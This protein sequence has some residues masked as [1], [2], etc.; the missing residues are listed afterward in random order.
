MAIVLLAQA[1]RA[2]GLDALRGLNQWKTV[3]CTL[4]MVILVQL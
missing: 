4:G 2:C 3:S 1:A